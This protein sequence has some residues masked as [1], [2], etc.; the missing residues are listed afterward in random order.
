MDPDHNS[1]PPDAG[2]DDRTRCGDGQVTGNE[3]CD[4]SIEAGQ[5]GACPTQ[6]P[7]LDTCV[8]RVLNGT[9]C[10]T[11]CV[12]RQLLCHSTKD[13][14]CLG[15]CTTDNDA[16]CSPTCGDGL[17]QESQGETCEKAG[18]AAPCKTEDAECDDNNP[19][20]TDKLIGSAANCNA[21]CTN[22]K[23]TDPKAGDACCPNGANA[24]TDSDC[25]PTCGNGVRETGEDCDGG[26]A[27]TAACKAAP[28]SDELRCLASAKDKCEMCACMNCAATEL[29]CR[30]SADAA[31]NTKCTA[32]ITCA[33]QNNCVGVP[34]YCG[35]DVLCPGL[36]G[37]GPCRA[38]IETAAGSTDPL[39]VSAQQ[40]DTTTPLGRSYTADACRVMQCRDS[41]R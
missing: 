37:W 32:V 7:P 34:C 38:P 40:Q 5:S 25:K 39:V 23:V 14:C 31:A 36:A 19:C 24:N 10:Q 15:N 12:L 11:E 35:S 27:C 1:A 28:Q 17:V 20:T 4:I 18:T 9:A 16:D 3:K 29:A 26:S 30:L 2:S 41:C 21:T 13:G 8:L 6:C 22:T 33:R